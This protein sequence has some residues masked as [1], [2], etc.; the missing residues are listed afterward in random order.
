MDDTTKL[1][2]SYSH[3][4]TYDDLPQATVHEAKRRIIDALGCAIAAYDAEPCAALRGMAATETSTTPST[5]L[6]DGTQTTPEAAAFANGVMVRFLDW[7]D[8]IMSVGSGHPSDL[9]PAALAVAESRQGSGRDLILGTTLG[10]EMFNVVADQVNIRERGWD[11]GLLVV[12]GAA[13]ASARLMGLSV[14]QMENAIAIAITANVPTRQTRAGEL[15]MWKGCAGPAAASGGVRAARLAEAGIT[16]PTEAFEGRHGFF[17]QVTGPFDVG[18]LGGQDGHPYA[19]ERSNL[20]SFPAEGHSQ[21]PIELALSLR[22]KVL[23]ADIEQLNVETY[24]MTYS[25]IGSEPAKWD[26][27]TRE[28]ADH[29]LPYLLAAALTDGTISPQTFNQ[30]RILDPALRPLMARIAVSEDPELTKR[31]PEMME[32]RFE[33]ITKSGER[34]TAQAQYPKGHV[35]NPMSDADVEAKFRSACAT[36]LSEAQCDTALDLLWR[37][38]GLDQV[39]DLFGAFAIR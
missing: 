3:T 2:A 35:Q 4:L 38:D 15:S 23:A 30:E 31:F 25:E 22:E 19:I 37:L 11:Q 24:W 13:A 9:M 6:G 20:K 12:L 34:F 36:Q 5:I 39:G 18:P 33:L 14:E 28:T 26:P 7:N 32:S 21:V 16:G 8:T 1:L 27:Q 29:S 17:E 10:Y